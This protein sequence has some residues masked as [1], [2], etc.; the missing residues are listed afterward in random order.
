MSSG[1]GE[2]ATPTTLDELQPKMK[3][4]GK[5]VKIELFGAFVDIGV[6][7]HGLLHISQLS[8]K[9]INNVSDILHE[10]DEITVWVKQVDPR[11]GRIDLTLIEPVAVSWDE[12]K[13]GQVYTGTVTRI[14][15]F[16]AF[17]EIGA[18]RPGL[19]HVSE[20]AS[21]YVSSPG[22]VVKVGDSIEVKVIKIDRKKRQIDLSV[23][24]LEQPLAAD[25]DEDEEELP[26]AMAMALRRAMQGAEPR[27]KQQRRRE[28]SRDYRNREIEDVIART[29][30]QHRSDD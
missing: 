11:A 29:L 19:V 1:N 15:K 6:G 21:G 20:L 27:P 22:D 24:A 16:G 7:R 12:I 5:V 18:E 17:V 30:E 2:Y 26:T 8:K 13:Q 4:R 28:K 10:G 25:E 14:E 23:K 3:L 9:H